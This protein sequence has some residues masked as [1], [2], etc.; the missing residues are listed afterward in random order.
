M[1]FVSTKEFYQTKQLRS[2]NCKCKATLSSSCFMPNYPCLQL[3]GRLF[4]RHSH[5]LLEQAFVWIHISWS[6]LLTVLPRLS[7]GL[8]SVLFA[9][10]LWLAAFSIPCRKPVKR[11]VFDGHY[12]SLSGSSERGPK[13]YFVPVIRKIQHWSSVLMWQLSR[14]ISCFPLLLPV[15]SHTVTQKSLKWRVHRKM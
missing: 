1:L 14:V 6:S 12:T 7:A 4:V 15:W 10:C 11:W 8:R 2:A 9:M 5:L 13:E 3:K